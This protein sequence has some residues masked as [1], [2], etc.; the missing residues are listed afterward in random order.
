MG[1]EIGSGKVE[2]IDNPDDHITF[3][4]LQWSRFAAYAWEKYQSEGRGALV[5]DLRNA[6]KSG[7]TLNVPTYYVA[8]GSEGLAKRGGWPSDDVAEVIR[9]YDPQLD[10][11]F[12][13]LRLDG[14]FF[15]YNVSDQLSPPEAHA[16]R[17]SS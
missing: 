13:V 7:T 17:A 6:S 9:S 11:V 5:I 12:I 3:I 4:R 1:L 16:R 2:D 14:D 10:V 15:H 8:E